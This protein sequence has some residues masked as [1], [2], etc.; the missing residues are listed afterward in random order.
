MNVACPE[1]RTIFRVDPAKVPD[2]GVRARCSACDRVMEI[3]RDGVIEQFFGAARSDDERAGQLDRD[4][5]PA[6]RAAG[7]APGASPGPWTTGTGRDAPASLSAAP[8]GAAPSAAAMNQP[9]FVDA[10]QAAAGA[11]E[12]VSGAAPAAGEAPGIGGAGPSTARRALNPF[13]ANDPNQR[14]RRLARALVS[15]IVAYYPEKRRE[16]MANG[17]LKELFREEIKK[18]YAEYADQVGGQFAASTAHFRDALNDLL[19]GGKPVF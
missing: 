3:G 6:P 1:C 10:G 13:L 8:T 7:D 5:A 19:T 2:A 9:D 16:G 18:S 11:R 17:T 15:D 4:E 14:A 12:P